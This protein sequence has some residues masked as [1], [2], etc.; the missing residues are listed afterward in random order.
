MSRPA[1]TGRSELKAREDACERL[2]ADGKAPAKD[3]A[4]AYAVRGDAL[5][6]KRNLDKAIEAYSKGIELDP[7]N[8][9][10]LNGRGWA[11]ESKGQDDLALADYNL[12]LAQAAEF[13]DGL[14]QSR[15]ALFRQGALQSALDD[16]DAAIR[17]TGRNC[18]CPTPTARA[19]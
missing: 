18:C 12:G 11:Y 14:Q 15:H 2:I 17:V 9:G 7:D 19:S 4:V 5:F 3:L 6:K 16:F 10:L 13:S 1:A 8:V